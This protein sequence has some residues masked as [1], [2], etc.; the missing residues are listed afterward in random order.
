M[1]LG[2]KRSQPR[3]ALVRTEVLPKLAPER[4]YLN[5]TP[6]PQYSSNYISQEHANKGTATD[7]PDT[8]ERPFVKAPDMIFIS[9]Q[10][11]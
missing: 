1:R 2:A 11:S 6:P 5:R 10:P 9:T 3:Q 8:Y 7:R 4:D